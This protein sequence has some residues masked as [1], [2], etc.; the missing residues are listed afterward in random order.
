MSHKFYFLMNLNAPVKL[1]IFTLLIHNMQITIDK[2][3]NPRKIHNSK[4]S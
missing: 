3:E 2:K 4:S 1:M